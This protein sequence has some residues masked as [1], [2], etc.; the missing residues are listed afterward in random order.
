MW[1]LG[2]GSRAPASLFRPCCKGLSCSR[3]LSWGRA[4]REGLGSAGPP[5]PLQRHRQ[6]GERYLCGPQPPRGTGFCWR[7]WP[8]QGRK[9]GHPASLSLAQ[10]HFQKFFPPVRRGKRS[11]DSLSGCREMDGQVGTRVPRALTGQTGALRPL[12]WAKEPF[13][14]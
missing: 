4:A 1:P 2:R 6:A 8:G 13:Q 3:S 10:P 9:Q 5:L 12:A 11:R 14:P 7:G